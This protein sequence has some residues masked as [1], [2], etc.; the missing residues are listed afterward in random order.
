MSGKIEAKKTSFAYK[1]V[2]GGLKLVY[3]RIEIVGLENV[4]EGECIVAANHCQMNGPIMGELYFPQPSYT[5]CAGEMLHWKEVPG[6]AFTDFWSFKPKWTH[7]FY[8]LLAYLITPLSVLV[9]NNANTIP[10]YH[11]ARIMTTFRETLK[12]LAQGHRIIIFP[13]KNVLHNN[14]IYDFQ[15]RFV[16]T[17]RMHYTKTHKELPFVPAYMAPKLHKMY[18]GQPVYYNAEATLEEERRRICDFLMGEITR[19]GV[20]AP[21]H[22][23]VP[24]RNIR[25]SDYPKNTPLKEYK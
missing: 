6:Y 14:I 2:R 7:W 4:P 10:V 5:W 25:N 3:P 17:A 24:Y 15:D 16:D 20:E 8:K 12:H 13:E 11:D 19:M 22:T 1:I 18:I 21:L 23:V 9:F